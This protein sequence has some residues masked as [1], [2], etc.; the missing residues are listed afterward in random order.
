M[1]RKKWNIA[2]CDKELAR[3][4][5]DE[6]GID[7]LVALILT[8][9]GCT[10][11][12]EID[13]LLSDESSLG[14]PYELPDM[15]QAVACIEA[16]ISA[17]S[18]IAVYGDYD[19][20]G[21]TSTA[22]VY[23]YLSSRGADVIYYVP[24]REEGYGMNCAAIDRLHADGVK[25]IITVDNGIVAFDEVEYANSLGM[26]VVITDHHLP[27]DSLPAAVAVVDPHRRD[28]ELSFRDFAGA[29]VA[30]KLICA[31]ENDD[32]SALYHR[33][34][35]LAAVG[36]IADVMPLV[37]EN[38]TIVKN[39]LPYISGGRV[40][41][42]ELIRVA[43]L[44]RK[45]LVAGSVSFGI[46]PRLNAAGRVGKCQRAVR[47]LLEND[48]TDAAELAEDIAASNVER[49]SIERGITEQ[50]VAII[51]RDRLMYDRVIVVNGTG[52]H[53]GVIGI[54]AARICERYGRPA[55]VLCTEDGVAAG[56]ARS[57]GEFS[58]YDAITSC[59]SVLTR[60][61]GHEQA[62]GVTL[63]SEDVDKFRELINRYAA[64]KYD[65]MPFDSLR[66]DCKLSPS[67]FTPD[68]VESLGVLAPF[69]VGNP[70]PLFGLCGVVINR[71]TPVGEGKH[72]RLEVGK[73]GS[74][75]TVMQFSCSES[76]FGYRVGMAVDLA[77]AADV[78]EYS[79]RK[80]VTLSVKAIRAA[81]GDEEAILSD[82]RLYERVRRGE[83]ISSQQLQRAALTREDVGNLYRNVRGGFGGEA[84]ALRAAL[85]QLSLLQINLA[86]DILSEI[87]VISLARS[88]SRLTVSPV[89]VSGK[90]DIT[91]SPTYKKFGKESR[92]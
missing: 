29:G 39:G 50:A 23:S 65:E 44:D 80:Q 22:M 14:D 10:D 79:G 84:E 86:A 21:V 85:P 32:G 13:Q 34:G 64:D 63:A 83:D 28:C 3:R 90:M 53:H 42:Q 70:A 67:A 49:Q 7:L 54:V 37:G 48:R 33:Y 16:A 27:G 41:L 89:A 56:S 43:G 59:E 40:G 2:K 60:F 26:Q 19:A 69:G 92:L 73:N 24:E 62:A 57:V 75:A 17:H 77:V 78:S 36:T 46:A 58:I 47:L 4:L 51:E 6:C 8:G 35:D 20:D 74:T 12:F 30:F 81:D 1:S 25:L 55:I 9:R 87:G 18:R 45:P 11:P 5:A 66:V 76:E 72:L 38:R 91:L 68:L 71:I 88:G 31:L 61:G 52:W 15:E 82:I